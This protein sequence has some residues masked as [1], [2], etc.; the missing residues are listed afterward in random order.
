M[1]SPHVLQLWLNVNKGM[2]PVKYF[3]SIKPSLLWHWKFYEDNW[4]ATK[5]GVSGHLHLLAVSL[6]LNHLSPFLICLCLMSSCCL[7]C[8]ESWTF[9]PQHTEIRYW[10]YSKSVASSVQCQYVCAH[11]RRS[12]DTY[13]PGDAGIW[14]I[15]DPAATSVRDNVLTCFKDCV[16][17]ACCF[18]VATLVFCVDLCVLP[19][20]IF[21]TKL[22]FLSD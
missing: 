7:L 17:A 13:I 16:L 1:R 22:L 15:R 21:C 19:E 9:I 11:A 20:W 8:V 4:N 12:Y 6:G 14:G 3:D 5:W 10:Q 18:L 2:L